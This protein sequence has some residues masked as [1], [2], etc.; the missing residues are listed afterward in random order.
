MPIQVRT[1]RMHLRLATF[2]AC[3]IFC[4]VTIA[5]AQQPAA[6]IQSYSE[7][8]S[9]SISTA[10]ISPDGKMVSGILDSSH[11]FAPYSWT[12][13]QGIVI[14]DGLQLDASDLRKPSAISARGSA[15]A[16]T[17]VSRDT[18][19]YVWT[20]TGGVQ[21]IGT[22]YDTKHGVID[23]RFVSDDGSVVLVTQGGFYAKKSKYYEH[24]LRWT[25]AEGMKD[26]GSPGFSI[27]ISDV[28][29]DGSLV[30]GSYTEASWT[31]SLLNTGPERPFRWTPAG[32]FQ[33]M[34]GMRDIH[35]STDGSTIVG[36]N[37]DDHIIRWTQA[38]GIQD[39]DTVKTNGNVTSHSRLFVSDN[40]SAIVGELEIKTHDNAL[41]ESHSFVWTQAGGLQDLGDLGGKQAEL[42]GVSADGTVVVGDFV[43]DGA[44]IRFVS[45]V[46]DL[47]AKRQAELKKEQALKQEQAQAQ[48]AAQEEENARN[49]AIQEDQQARYDKI[50]ITGRP[51]QIY[52]L[53]GDLED[54]GRPDL[55]LNLYQALID[56]F[57]DDPYAAKA[58]EKKEALRAAQQQAQDSGGQQVAANSSSPQAIEA[59]IQQCS[60][61]L[62][63]CKA[64]AQTQHDSAV[65]KGLVGLLSKNAGMVGGAGTD[66]QNADSAKSACNDD[67][68]SCSAA[69]Q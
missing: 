14:G 10:A 41:A 59:C 9:T 61:T 19:F 69:C 67:Y 32:G 60:T 26:V 4:F 29:A 50:V 64:N 24:L 17:Y 34:R 21:N 52:S 54:E 35:L 46:A 23:I 28:S 15:A 39:L 7:I 1:C 47:V 30:V 22:I 42:V 3:A 68:N 45:P 44:R 48:K 43:G 37:G 18:A 11:N 33:D 31:N 38:G 65:A 49:A 57:P 12:P 66:S 8:K 2:V 40:G 58:V 13:S 27:T 62:N 53:A 6:K 25:K 5:S 20:R 16:G 63:S 56:K 55:A 51:I 36:W